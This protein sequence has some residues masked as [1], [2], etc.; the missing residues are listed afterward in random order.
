MVHG[1]VKTYDDFINN[2]ILS[3]AVIRS[4]E[5]I[6]EASKKIPTEFKSR[7]P[8]VQ[9]KDISGM[10]DR[11]I[12]HYFG[13]DHEIVWNTINEDLPVF[14]EWIDIMLEFAINNSD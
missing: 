3:R 1:K 10:R 5:I 2:P 14:N 6:G 4:L 7:F 11:L 12:H 13:V 8:L 9:W